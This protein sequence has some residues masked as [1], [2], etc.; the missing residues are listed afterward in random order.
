MARKVPTKPRHP[1]PSRASGCRASAATAAPLLRP[2]PTPRATS[3]SHPESGP[4]PTARA[5]AATLPEPAASPAAT[6]ATA[7][8]HERITPTQ[9]AAKPSAL[10]RTQP[11]QQPPPTLPGLPSP[12]STT[13]LASQPSLPAPRPYAI[14]DAPSHPYANQQ[15]HRPAAQQQPAASSAA[16]GR[17]SLGNPNSSDPS[18]GGASAWASY[19]SGYG[20][21]LAEGGGPHRSGPLGPAGGMGQ[22]PGPAWPSREQQFRRDQGVAGSRAA[23]GG[24]DEEAQ[25]HLAVME[26]TSKS[27]QALLEEQGASLAAVQQRLAQSED[28]EQASR[29]RLTEWFQMRADGSGCLGSISSS[30]DGAGSSGGDSGSSSGGSGNDDVESQL[31]SRDGMLQSARQ[32]VEGLS[33]ELRRAQD[34]LGSSRG[35]STDSA[36]ELAMA[37]DVIREMR[38]DGEAV[39]RK[40]GT[41]SEEERRVVAENTMLRKENQ[42]LTSALT[43]GRAELNEIREQLRASSADLHKAASHAALVTTHAE[44]DRDNIASQLSMLRVQC[45]DLQSRNSNLSQDLESAREGSRR[46][47]TQHQAQ[48]SSITSRPAGIRSDHEHE[49]WTSSNNPGMQSSQALIQGTQHYSPNP[50]QPRPSSWIPDDVAPRE[51]SYS[52]MDPET[53]RAHVRAEARAQMDR[54]VSSAAPGGNGGSSGGYSLRPPPAQLSQSS[55]QGRSVEAGSRPPLQQQQQIPSPPRLQP[56]PEYPPTSYGLNSARA[57]G[58]PSYGYV[59]TSGRLGNQPS[60]LGYSVGPPPGPNNPPQVP[61]Y[62]SSASGE[63]SGSSTAAAAAAANRPPSFYA[64]MMLDARQGGGTGS[65]GVSDGMP[66]AGSGVMGSSEYTS[67]NSVAASQSGPAI[68]I[69]ANRRLPPPQAPDSPRLDYSSAPSQQQQ[70]VSSQLSPPYAVQSTNEARVRNAT[71]ALN[72]ALPYGTED[73]LKEMMVKSRAMEDGLVVLCGEKGTLEAEFAKLPVHGRS[74]KERGRKVE[75]ERRLEGLNREISNLRLTLRR[76]HGK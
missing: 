42:F 51:I 5:E 59:S 45:S 70:P 68:R 9:T 12:N 13:Q 11:N 4:Q 63:R 56:A 26:R 52:S 19:V 61:H 39:T 62:A 76:L 43:K 35:R 28:A 30:I 7:A 44:M 49:I 17:P 22:Q 3:H 47:L 33:S 41:V 55:I 50:I 18:A 75:V 15:L 38:K 66:H 46:A 23:A 25:G 2:S 29:R 16:A 37:Q 36:N 14:D 40:L 34:E 54:A 31:R 74:Q 24:A 53:F 48:Q 72:G 73:T 65:G 69:P 8:A 64:A 67:G 20:P 21:R 58:V 6:A 10:W 60:G 32:H 71:A 57:S 27:L 1:Q